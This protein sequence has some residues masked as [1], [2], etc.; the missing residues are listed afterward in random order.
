M[1]GVGKLF[2]GDILNKEKKEIDLN[3]PKY[4]E[5]IF[6]LY[7]SAQWFVSFS[8]LFNLHLKFRCG[9][10]RH[11][12]P[13]LIKFYEKYHQ[14]KNLEIIF[15]SSDRDEKS[16]DEYYLNMPWFYLDYQQRQKKDI[17]AKHFHVIGIP[18]L[19]LLDANSG[20]II[21]T[22]AKDQIEEKDPLGTLFPWKN[23]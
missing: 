18:T 6:G 3:D 15:L 10:C 13:I 14:E 21:C 22:D 8:F 23:I 2:D 12:S 7:F 19:I 20:E 4:Q 17:L 5:K 1:T 9:P 16:F 11:F